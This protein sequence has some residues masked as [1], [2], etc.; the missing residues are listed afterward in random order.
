MAHSGYGEPT[1]CTYWRSVLLSET[2]PQCNAQNPFKV[3]FIDLEAKRKASALAKINQ[4][5]QS[6]CFNWSLT[7]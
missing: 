7:F 4:K 1:L 6:Q 3:G 5:P 2:Q